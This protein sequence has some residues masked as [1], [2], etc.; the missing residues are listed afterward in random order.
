MG[1]LGRRSSAPMS[2][3]QGVF[4]RHTLSMKLRCSTCDA[5][6]LNAFRLLFVRSRCSYCG[7][8]NKLHLPILR[9]LLIQGF[10]AAMFVTG[11]NL[12]DGSLSRLVLV[13]MVVISLIAYVTIRSV[14]IVPVGTGALEKEET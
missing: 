8:L 6:A 10:A 9:N 5:K 11:F 12:L 7:Q 2:V 3:E 13:T 1:R 14:R 4:E